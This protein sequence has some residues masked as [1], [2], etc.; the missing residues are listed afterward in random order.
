MRAGGGLAQRAATLLKRW[1]A[2]LVTFD[3]SGRYVSVDSSQSVVGIAASIPYTAGSTNMNAAVQVLEARHYDRIVILSDMQNWVTGQ[4]ADFDL[5]KYEKIARVQPW[6]YFF[7]LTASGTVRVP[8]D[9]VRLI[10]GWSDADFKLFD[11]LETDPQAPINQVQN[12]RFAP[13]AEANL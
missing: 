2:E 4:T 12:M 11:R 5:R 9:R 10:S 6:V 8:P 13:S 1:D 3:G 7:D